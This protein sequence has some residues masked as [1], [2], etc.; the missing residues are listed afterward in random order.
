M[1]AVE[2]QKSTGQVA[3]MQGC[4]QWMIYESIFEI[5]SN[6]YQG[7]VTQTPNANKAQ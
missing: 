1:S 2:F 7:T 4:G 6:G 5:L 3:S